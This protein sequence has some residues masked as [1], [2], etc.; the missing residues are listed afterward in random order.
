MGQVPRG[1]VAVTSL[2]LCKPPL[3]LCTARNESSEEAGRRLE[4]VLSLVLQVTHESQ[5]CRLNY[6]KVKIHVIF[7]LVCCKF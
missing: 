2:L 7:V 3:R 5:N 1:M 4:L 6:N